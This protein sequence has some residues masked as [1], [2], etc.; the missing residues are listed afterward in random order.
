MASVDATGTNNGGLKVQIDSSRTRQ[1][2][3]TDF[4]KV[5][6]KSGGKL[7]TSGTTNNINGGVQVLLNRAD[8]PKGLTYENIKPK[9]NTNYVPDGR[10]DGKI[11]LTSDQ[12]SDNTV[13]NKSINPTGRS[14]SISLQNTDLP[15]TGSA[16]FSIEA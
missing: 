10:N 5:F 9:S 1:T 13:V 6:P 3:K 4:G 15:S 16:D 2:P 14:G 7:P 11:T 12:Q 8:Q